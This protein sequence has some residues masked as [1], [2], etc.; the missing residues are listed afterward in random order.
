MNLSNLKESGDSWNLYSDGISHPLNN[1]EEIFGKYDRV[2]AYQYGPKNS[3]QTL[4]G[5]P[6][7]GAQVNYS[8]CLIENVN[9]LANA[10]VW[11]Y[12]QGLQNDFTQA[13]NWKTSGGQPRMDLTGFTFHHA[14]APL[15]SERALRMELR[16]HKLISTET[17]GGDYSKGFWPA[18]SSFPERIIKVLV[19]EGFE[20]SVI[21]NSHLARI[22]DDYPLTYGTSGVNIDPPNTADKV[23]TKGVNWLNGQIDGRGGS[24]AAPYTYQAHKAVSVDPETGTELKMVGLIYQQINGMI[25]VLQLVLVIFQMMN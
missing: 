10:S 22:L 18:E 1:L 17:F 11:G 21:A 19:Q 4:L 24:F 12:N 23:A 15:I 8:G 3:V 6:N 5:L 20:W 9:S 2:K 16:T 25:A 14:L 13:K 7:G